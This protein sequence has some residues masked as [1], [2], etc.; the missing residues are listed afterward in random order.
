MTPVLDCQWEYMTDRPNNKI[1]NGINNYFSTI[2]EQ[3]DENLR[4]KINRLIL[5]STTS[6]FT[7]NSHLKQFLFHQQ[8]A[9]NYIINKLNNSKSPG[10]DNIG[11]RLIKDVSLLTTILIPCPYI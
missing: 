6:R 3:L 2:N 7:A 5:I 8:T 11:S 10:Y 1:S 4:H 9:L